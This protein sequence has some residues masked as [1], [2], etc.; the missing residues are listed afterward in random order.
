M[1]LEAAAG[2]NPVSHV[3]KIYNVLAARMAEAIVSSIPEVS[4]A[5]CLIVSKIG[6]AV[7]SPAL[8]HVKL[9]TQDGMPPDR[10][11][12]RIEEITRDQLARISE[13][14]SELVAGNVH[15]F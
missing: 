7:S 3:G 6:A 15:V 10:V 2:K 1:S 14:I 4:S 8:V 13:L 9:A 5:H 12:G 11:K